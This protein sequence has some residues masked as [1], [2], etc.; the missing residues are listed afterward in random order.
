ME[1]INYTLIVRAVLAFRDFGRGHT[2]VQTFYGLMKM[3]PPM[4]SK[5]YQDTVEYMH[6]LYIESAEQSMKAA[7]DDIRKELLGDDYDEETCC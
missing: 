7:A 2:D 4:S 6:P 5:T 1:S 3:P